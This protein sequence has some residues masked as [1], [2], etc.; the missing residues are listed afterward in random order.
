MYKLL[1]YVMFLHFVADFLLQ[2]REMG[3]KKSVEF[4]WLAKHLSI[5]YLVMYFGLVLF[6]GP[7]AAC[8]LSL[9]NTLVHGLIDWNIWKLYKLSAHFRI[10]REIETL[11]I[12]DE[13]DAIR[14]EAYNNKVNNWKYWD[15]HLFYT[16]IGFDQFLHMTTLAVLLWKL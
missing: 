7:V 15:D 3:Q 1:I 13:H 10:M 4:K 14:K 12:D 8:K 2:S 6:I 11:E 9:L 16:T 5:Q